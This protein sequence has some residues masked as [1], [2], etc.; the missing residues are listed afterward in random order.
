MQKTYVL[1]ANV[2]LQAPYA[3]E[4]FEDNHIVLPLAV[5]EELDDRKGADGEAGNNARHVLRFLERLRLQGDLVKGVTLPSGGTVRLEVNHVDAALPQGIEPGSRA[6][7]VLKVCRGLMDEGA[8]VTL[9]SRDM[10]ARIRAQMMEVPAEDFTTDRLPD[11]AQPYT[12]RAEVY[13]SDSL[14]TAFKK[15]GAP[16]EELYTVD[17]AGERKPVS[18]TE[19]QFV[20]VTAL[21]FGGVRPFGVK[22]RSVGQQFLQEALLLPVA[23]A[24]LAIIQGPAGTAKTF[25]ALAAGLEQ[26]L[27]AEERP[28]RKILVCRPNAQFDADIGFLPGSEQE[29]IS[30]LMRPIVDNLE[31]LL[32][33]EG[34]KKE[35]RSEE[36]LRGRID[37]LFDTGVIAA[38]AMNFMRGRSITDTWH[39]P[40]GKGHQGSAAGGPGPDR[41][42]PAGHPEQRIDLR[43]RPH[44]G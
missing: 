22:P 36:E 4:S 29:K 21:R 42:P 38:E 8:P 43:Q 17:G 15:K 31:I 1:D 11:G 3:L 40:G 7:R 27:E 41:P 37:Y 9:V 33:L 5:L 14:L 2:L 35:R 34:K 19:N 6:G 32:D 28:Y 39:H 30:S 16:A 23:E 26:V 25:Y 10:V 44:E 13:I 18:L 20:Q 12:G 24:P